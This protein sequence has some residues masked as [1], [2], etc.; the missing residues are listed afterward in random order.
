[1]KKCINVYDRVAL[2][3]P[4]T[5]GTAGLNTDN[6]NEFYV[7]YS[8]GSVTIIRLGPINGNS[9][10]KK[11]TRLDLAI[12]QPAHPSLLFVYE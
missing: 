3:Y 6:V 1:M 5:L 2:K 9:W 8:L 4:N 10:S 11:V 12:S 7:E